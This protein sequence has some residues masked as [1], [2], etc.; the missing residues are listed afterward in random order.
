MVDLTNG[1]E[2]SW[3]LAGDTWDEEGDEEDAS[4][5]EGAVA[6]EDAEEAQLPEH[7]TSRE[8]LQIYPDDQ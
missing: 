8:I 3:R 7:V 1:V 5:E 6:G 4:E 2:L